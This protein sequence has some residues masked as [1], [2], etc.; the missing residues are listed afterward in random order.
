MSRQTDSMDPQAG[1]SNSAGGW[2]TATSI[3][4]RPLPARAALDLVMRFGP[5][6]R[7][8]DLCVACPLEFLE[9]LST[10]VRIDVQIRHA[11]HGGQLFEHEEDR[12]ILHERAPV[13]AADHVALLLRQVPRLE[14]RL[15]IGL[16][17]RTVCR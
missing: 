3:A 5:S 17:C 2:S 6:N 7:I 10:H 14:Q 8:E 9:R 15:R 16:E 1:A 13:A 4:D 12:A 11:D